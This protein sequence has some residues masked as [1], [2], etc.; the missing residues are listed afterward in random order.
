MIDA[1]YNLTV[2]PPCGPNKLRV[3]L[4]LYRLEAFEMVQAVV[5]VALA[6]MTIMLVVEV[7]G[8]DM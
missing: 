7:V 1:I 8:E 4:F 5:Q 2:A 6:R 3:R